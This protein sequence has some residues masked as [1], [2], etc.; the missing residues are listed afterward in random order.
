MKTMQLNSQASFISNFR[1]KLFILLAITLA[2]NQ[3]VNSQN[4]NYLT[5]TGNIGTTYSWIDC[6]GGS[7]I[8]SGRASAAAINW[9]FNFRFYNSTYTSS[10]TLSVCTNGFIRLDGTASTTA[11]TASA[12][13]L[14]SASTEL[15]QIVALGVYENKVG[16]GGGWVRSATTGTAPNRIFTIEYNNLEIDFNDGFYADLQVSFYETSNKIV[17]KFG[18]DNVNKTGADIGLHSGTSGY[19]NDWQDVDNGTNNRW[20][21]Y[22]L[23]PV[24]VNATGGTTLNNYNTIIK[25]KCNRIPFLCKYSHYTYI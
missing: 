10:N 5:T 16:D 19:F 11:A 15:G 18:A 8:T 20:I 17:L 1:V 13:T 7:N 24:E 23:P 22:T 12:Y 14:G 25:A 4:F 3:L 9:P 2:G 6:S 21:E